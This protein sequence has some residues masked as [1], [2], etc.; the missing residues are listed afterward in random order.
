MAK[1]PALAQVTPPP[2]REFVGEGM[3]SP[4]Q[5]REL[6]TYVN[7]Q[8]MNVERG[9]GYEKRTMA[10]IKKKAAAKLPATADEQ[11]VVQVVQKLLDFLRND[12]GG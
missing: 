4:S 10:A 6:F 12:I 3:P 7:K 2:P 5:M 8:H 11:N 1:D 9:Q